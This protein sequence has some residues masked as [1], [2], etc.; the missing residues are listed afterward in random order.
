MPALP[1][2]NPYRLPILERLARDGDAYAMYALSNVLPTRSD[3]N[4]GAAARRWLSR[5]ARTLLKAQLSLVETSPRWGSLPRAMTRRAL[6]WARRAAQTRHP[7]ALR[8]VAWQPGGGMRAG[9]MRAARAGSAMAAFDLAT[10]VE[11]FGGDLRRVRRWLRFAVVVG[12]HDD[13]VEYAEMIVLRARPYLRRFVARPEAWRRRAEAGDP[14]ALVHVGFA[15]R[16][17][18]GEPYDPA[19][20]QSAFESAARGESVDGA[21]ALALLVLDPAMDVEWDAAG[22]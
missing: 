11:I 21:I 2:P 7:D 5:A 6:G 12:M 13:M 4:V 3:G 19:L 15:R 16:F 17:G 18:R 8:A 10:I 22:A 14:E 9:L 20:A 1:I